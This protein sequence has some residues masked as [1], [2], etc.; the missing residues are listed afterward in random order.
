MYILYL[1]HQFLRDLGMQMLDRLHQILQLHHL[2]HCLY[3]FLLRDILYHPHFHIL[4]LHQ[5]VF[6]LLR[7]KVN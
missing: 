5:Q 7:V 1:L 2:H 4:L 6:D 3:D